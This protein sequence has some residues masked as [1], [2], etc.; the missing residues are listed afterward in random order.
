[1]RVSPAVLRDEAEQALMRWPFVLDIEDAHGLPRFLLLAVG[2]IET[3]LRPAFTDG[4]TTG[5]GGHGHGVWQL[6]DR[7]HVI[8]PGFDADP[9][10]QAT[11]AAGMLGALLAAEHDDVVRACNRYNS[12][13]ASDGAA[14]HGAGAD[15]WV[16]GREAAERLAWLTD[17]LTPTE[18]ED[19]DMP[20]IVAGTPSWSVVQQ[21]LARP[22][23]VALWETTTSD[24]FTMGNALVA[25][26][27]GAVFAPVWTMEHRGRGGG[28]HDF[29][30]Q[31]HQW[32]RFH[33]TGVPIDF[34]ETADG[35]FFLIADNGTYDVAHRSRV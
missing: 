6:D 33:N 7:F 13:S 18:R 16:Y 14:T 29:S 5:D 8:P 4:H 23:F 27:D 30:W 12:G 19:E 3:N 11:T 25:A 17:N 10:A 35:A 24:D 21:N 15:A 2:S 22:R 31:G 32:R 1:M 34:D 20:R 26:L 9:R 28:W